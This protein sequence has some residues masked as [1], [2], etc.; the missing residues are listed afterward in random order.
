MAETTFIGDFKRNFFTGIAALFPILITFFLFSWVYG[1][2]DR[3]I[4]RGFTAALV[5]HP[6]LF[7]K[8]FPGV[9]PEIVEDEDVEK[10]REY[11]DQHLPW[12]IRFAAV[13]VGIVAA[14]VVVYLT[15]IFLRGY[16]GA[17]IMRRMDRLFERF[18]LVKSVYPHAR[19]V[20]DF[21]F[22]GPGRPQ[23]RRVVA[24]QYP[25]RGIYTVGLVTGGGLKGIEDETGL[26][27]VTVFMPT[28]PTPVTGFVI[29]VPRD[30]V[31]ELDMN[32][33]DTLKFAMTAGMVAG[34]RQRPLTVPMAEDEGE[35]PDPSVGAR[36]RQAL[37][38]RNRSESQ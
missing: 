6:A 37:L 35:G 38:N 18:P 15:G 28:S 16:F 12:S 25:R 10:R 29:L 17:R 4:N 14:L 1:H 22:G 11:V 32:V 34:T 19:Q 31:I 9:P 2:L 8:V 5:T 3:T 26:D 33:E 13:T 24:V 36:L 21:M 27:F 30:S 23:F 7:A 20:A